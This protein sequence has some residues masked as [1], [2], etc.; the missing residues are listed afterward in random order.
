MV[1]ALFQAVLLKFMFRRIFVEYCAMLWEAKSVAPVESCYPGNQDCERRQTVTRT[2]FQSVYLIFHKEAV[3]Q[4]RLAEAFLIQISFN[5]SWI[6]LQMDCPM[7]TRVLNII[8]LFNNE[9]QWEHNTAQKIFSYAIL[10][11]C[12]YIMHKKRY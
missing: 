1:L 11:R 3:A 6:A 7:E 10:R 9:V 5:A 8:R 2:T 12:E 4:S